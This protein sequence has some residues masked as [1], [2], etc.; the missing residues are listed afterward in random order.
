MFESHLCKPC[1]S[2][3]IASSYVTVGGAFWI[4]EP[5][6]IFLRKYQQ[7]SNNEH[8]EHPTRRA[9]FVTMVDHMSF[10]VAMTTDRKRY[11]VVMMAL[12]HFQ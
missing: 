9:V 1:S 12:Y 7:T 4:F 10:V 5:H 6:S 11:V 2:A 8:K 3:A